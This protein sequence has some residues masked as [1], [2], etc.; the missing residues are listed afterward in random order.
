MF[1]V[2]SFAERAG[3]AHFGVGVENA[4]L[5]ATLGDSGQV[6]VQN[7]VFGLECCEGLSAAVLRVDV[8]REQPRVGQAHAYTRVRV[9]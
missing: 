1:Q 5:T 4:M 2:K 7:T 3:V 8:E 9:G 6:R